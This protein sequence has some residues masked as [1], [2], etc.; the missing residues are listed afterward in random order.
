MA[1]EAN[2][3]KRERQKRRREE[4]RRREMAAAK[5]ARTMRLTAFAVVALVIVAIVGVLVRNNL[6]QRAELA[7]Q[8]EQVAAQ[9]DDFGCTEDAEQP[10]EGVGHLGGGQ[11][12]SNPP[13]VIYP[14]RPASSGQH[15]A[16]WII[17]G[18]YDKL[19]DE[20]LLV[21][22]LEHGYI[23]VYYD[24]GADES[25]VAEIEAWAQEK[26][27]G[28]D[29]QKIV[30]APWDGELPDDANVAFTAWRYRQ[31]CEEFSPDVAD[32]F[33]RA[34]HGLAGVAPE[35]NLPPHRRAPDQG[36]DPNAEEGDLL[37]PPLGDA[38]PAGAEMSERATE[39]A[40]D[41]ASEGP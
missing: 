38:D 2:L 9:L 41:D 3:S 27:D 24:D 5:R 26:I 21:H 40:T 35:K 36:I 12:A 14:D 16:S 7:A 23:N 4:K 30:V 20:R 10:D 17:S 31:L 39:E 6:A 8:E 11:L 33:T 18:V 29:F 22:N 37:L 1:D 32:V 13:D 28:G 15:I 25:T 34:H 19:I